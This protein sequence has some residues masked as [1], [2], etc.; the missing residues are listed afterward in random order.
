MYF[1]FK[2]CNKCLN[3]IRKSWKQEN[4]YWYFPG[5]FIYWLNAQPA[6]LYRVPSIYFRA[7]LSWEPWS[8][9]D[10]PNLKFSFAQPPARHDFQVKLCKQL[11]IAKC[12]KFGLTRTPRVV[13]AIY[14]WVKRTFLASDLMY[15]RWWYTFLASDLMYL[16]WWYTKWPQLLPK[17]YK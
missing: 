4:T 3:L 7:C 11:N 2:K 9:F 16:R 12:A 17:V 15:L 10:T 13:S 14:R 8:N 5:I 1:C 6:W